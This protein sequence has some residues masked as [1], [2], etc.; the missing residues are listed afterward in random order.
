MLRSNIVYYRDKKLSVCA[1]HKCGSTSIIQYLGESL[2]LHYNYENIKTTKSRT[3]IKKFFIDLNYWKIPETWKDIEDCDIKI[4][5]VRDPVERLISV[6]NDRII[7]RNR[8]NLQ[9]KIKNFDYFV[10]NLNDLR[11]ESRHLYNHS[12]PQVEYIGTNTD[13]FTHIIKTDELANIFPTI[14]GIP[15]TKIFHLKKTTKKFPDIILS[16]QIKNKIYEYY[17]EDYLIWSSYF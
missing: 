5:V 17:K 4:V 2:K 3:Y 12:Q 8:D 16:T 15:T 6:Y 11:E 9:T 1:A 10:C 13:R 14:L 7:K